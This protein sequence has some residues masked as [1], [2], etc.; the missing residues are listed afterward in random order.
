MVKHILF[1]VMGKK[2]PFQT[3][4]I[5]NPLSYKFVIKLNAT[6]V[7]AS[8]FGLSRG[9]EKNWGDLLRKDGDPEYEDKGVVERGRKRKG[10]QG[11]SKFYL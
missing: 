3:R 9:Q 6:L 5:L 8:V 10:L 11:H 2:Q 4:E 7:S 1:Y